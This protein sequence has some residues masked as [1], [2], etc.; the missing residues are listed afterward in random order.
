MIDLR[1]ELAP[2]EEKSLL[3]SLLNSCLSE[4]S[5]YGDVDATYPYFDAYWDVDE[6]RWPYLIRQGSE[7][8]GFAFVNTWSPSG[9]GTDFAIAEFYVTPNARQSGIG[10][11]AA[12]SIFQRHAGIWE[13]SIMP[14]NQPAKRFWPSAIEASQA[15]M[16]EHMEVDGETIYRF[17]IG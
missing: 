8:V 15:K 1:V 17:T 13:L 5:L 14:L 6:R 16:V 12:N 11:E 3:Y 10:R 2:V 9:K 4:L 7:I